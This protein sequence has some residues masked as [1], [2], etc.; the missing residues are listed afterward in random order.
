MF[1]LSEY[2]GKGYGKLLL[3]HAIDS[4]LYAKIRPRIPK[5]FNVF[6]TSV[7]EIFFRFI[8]GIYRKIQAQCPQTSLFLSKKQG[9]LVLLG[10]CEKIP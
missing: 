1:V 5:N 7:V 10:I 6:G 8:Q 3:K 2:Q 9:L 4:A